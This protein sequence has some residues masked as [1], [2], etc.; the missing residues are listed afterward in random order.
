VSKLLSCLALGLA[1]AAASAA[2][3]KKP[4]PTYTNQDLDRVAPLRGQTGALSEPA[5]PPT[6]EPPPGSRSREGEEA[7]W[8]QAAQRHRDGLRALEGRAADLRLRIEEL[9]RAA[10]QDSGT[11]SRSGAKAPGAAV[12]AALVRLRRLEDDIRR[13][14]DEFE[15]R[16]RRARAL[17]GWL[18]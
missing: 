5:T 12:D 6:A 4:V 8:R 17:P 13:R 7:R 10:A 11:R 2:E 16:A 15:E 9:R 1:C 18:R 14:Q 3:E